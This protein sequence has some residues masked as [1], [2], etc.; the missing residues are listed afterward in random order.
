[1]VLCWVASN[2]WSDRATYFRPDFRP[3]I[4]AQLRFARIKWSRCLEHIPM[5]ENLEPFFVNLDALISC[6]IKPFRIPFYINNPLNAQNIWFVCTFWLSIAFIL[7]LS[8]FIFRL[9]QIFKRG[10]FY[11]TVPFF[12]FGRRSI[13]IELLMVTPTCQVHWNL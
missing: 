10:A 9:Y 11:Y 6:T 1:M 5:A 3:L 12:G 2:L 13:F 4:Q 8:S 7:L